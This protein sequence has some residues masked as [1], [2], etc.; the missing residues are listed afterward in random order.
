MQWT[1]PLVS[2]DLNTVFAIASLHE[3][4]ALISDEEPEAMK[5][6][7][8]CAAQHMT[9]TTMILR[10]R[11]LYPNAHPS[12]YASLD[13]EYRA[14]MAC[15]SDDESRGHNGEK[16]NVDSKASEAS[17]PHICSLSSYDPVAESCMDEMSRQTGF[18]PGGALCMQ[19]TKDLAHCPRLWI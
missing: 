8:S 16:Q 19:H 1:G 11:L 4:L 5:A 9:Y 7:M 15:K 14:F 13:N 12:E 3:R 10:V 2:L 17:H 6:G 18:I